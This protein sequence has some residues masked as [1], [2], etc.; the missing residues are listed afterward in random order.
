MMIATACRDCAGETDHCHEA[1]I[2]H[3]DQ[4]IECSG[5]ECVAVTISHVHVIQCADLRPACGCTAGAA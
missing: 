3:V 1:L 4:T 5:G 2:V